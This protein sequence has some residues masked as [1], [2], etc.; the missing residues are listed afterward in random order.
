MKTIT[1]SQLQAICD[2]INRMTGN[3]LASYTKTDSGHKANIGNYHIDHAYGGVSLHRMMSEG[4]AVK[5]IFRCGHV[6]KRELAEKMWA[7]VHGIEAVQSSKE[8]AA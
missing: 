8:V 2:R 4:G 3:P 6:P 1:E 7:F 5:D